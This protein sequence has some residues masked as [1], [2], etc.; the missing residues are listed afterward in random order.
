[1]SGGNVFLALS[2]IVLAFLGLFLLLFLSITMLRRAETVTRG[3]SQVLRIP[4]YLLS[5]LYIAS[6]VAFLIR[7]TVA[8][9]PAIVAI[10]GSIIVGLILNKGF[11]RTLSEKELGLFFLL[12]AF[13]G[14]IA[15]YYY[16][17]TQTLIYSLHDMRYSA[18]WMESPF[19]WFDNYRV[20]FA[21][22]N[23]RKAF[24]F[25]TYFA[26]GTVTLCF[27][28]GLG[29]A[30]A[31]YWIQGHLRGFIRAVIIIPWAIPLVIT[32][33]IWRWTLNSDVGPFAVL[34]QWGLIKTVPVFLSEPFWA[35]HSVIFADAWKWSPLV[36]IFLIGALSTIP[37]EMYDAAKV[38]GA[39]AI[40]RFSAITLPMIAPTIFVALMFRTMEALRV[41]DIVYSMTG[42]GP[43]TTTETL[44]TF[45]Y[46]YY[47]SYARFGIGSAYAMV[48]FMII[49][50]LSLLYVNRIYKN[51][52]FR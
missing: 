16:P 19:I 12:P 22:E 20:A 39:G 4:V 50:S 11:D 14:V 1:M 21:S 5:I 36:A 42:G 27:L 28:I 13:L 34:R 9:Y 2:G 6:L 44:S 45:A 47:F 49:L 46:K 24:G 29:M 35:V 40:R 37:Q 51:L 48:V 38:D 10:A 52:R 3:K 18:D 26:F 17:I 32:A 7:P 33:S 31:S 41:F 15:L 30:L 43:G 8:I 23:F 25:T